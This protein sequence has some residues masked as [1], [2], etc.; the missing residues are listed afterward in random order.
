MPDQVSTG[1]E[2]IS[3]E[4]WH[5]IFEYFDLNDLWYS[6]RRLNG[7][8]NGIID[9]TPLHLNFRSR[10]AYTNY[11]KK[12]RRSMNPA[13]VRSLLLQQPEEI[14][15]FFS[16]HPLKS[17]T[18]LRTLSVKYM[19]CSDELTLQFWNQLSSL[20]HLQSLEVCHCWYSKSP[21]CIEKKE[22]IIQ[23][24]FNHDYW[25]ALKS[26]AIDTCEPRNYKYSIASLVPPTKTNNLQYLIIDRLAFNDL[27]T[28]LPALG[29]IKLLSFT[30]K[31]GE[32]EKSMGKL[33]KID[34]PLL[35]KCLNLKLKLHNDLTFEHVEY[36]LGQT[37]NLKS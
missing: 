25:P 35:S 9:Q 27:V 32:D 22:S 4:L 26:L 1:I 6:F 31:L 11:A 12:I 15:H 10:G 7:R 20:K 2:Q 21:S 8:I 29:N 30:E 28:V 13:N 33:P 23:S 24:I 14:R 3:V 17:L 34:T 36:L 37:P 18:Q 16:I 5:E 19:A